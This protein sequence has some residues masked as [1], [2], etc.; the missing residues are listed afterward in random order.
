VSSQYNRKDHLYKKAKEE[1]LNSRAAFKLTEI[2]KRFKLLKKGGNILDLGC[3]PGGWIQVAA[4]RVGPTGRVYGVDLREVSGF[5]NQP[6]IRIRLGDI[7]D[8]ATIDDIRE[9]FEGAPL[10]A[11]ISDLSHQL[12]GIRLKDVVQSAELMGR[13]F[14]LGRLLLKPGGAVVAKFFP[15]QDTEDLIKALRKDFK[16]LKRVTL[17]SSRKSSIEQY[18]VGTG[19]K[20]V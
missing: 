1:G 4:D 9:F 2:D 3:F 6:N 7:Y 8:P 12:T 10:D 16:E 15:G 13:A 19:I 18:V 11:V 5:E 17:D 20:L 14:E